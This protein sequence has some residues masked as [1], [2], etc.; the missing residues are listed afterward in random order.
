MLRLKCA[1]AEMKRI[2]FGSSFAI[3]VMFFGLATLD[4]F[5]RRNWSRAAFWTVIAIGFL[6]ASRP[7][8]F[9]RCLRA[10]TH[11]GREDRSV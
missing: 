8:H 6:I 11:G 3:F 9:M 10:G 1:E 7:A 4:A 5:Q 2:V